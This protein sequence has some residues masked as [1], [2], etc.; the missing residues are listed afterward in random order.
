MRFLHRNDINFTKEKNNN[1]NNKYENEMKRKNVELM[2]GVGISYM[3]DDP[4]IICDNI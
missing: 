1:N 2:Y 3:H 4:D